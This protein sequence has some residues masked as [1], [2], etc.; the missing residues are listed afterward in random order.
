LHSIIDG[1]IIGRTLFANIVKYLRVTF[2]GNFGNLF[3]IAIA[4]AFMRFIPLLPSQLL[5]INFLSDLPA[6][7]FSFDNVDDTELRQPKKWRSD[8]IIKNG[9]TFGLI[10]TIFDLIL[11]FYLLYVLNVFEE[12]FRSV[13]FLEIILTEV[14]VIFFL[15]TTKPF[16]FSKGPSLILVTA[17]IFSTLVGFAALYPPLST[18]L[19][20]QTPVTDLILF[21]IL[22]SLGYALTTEF[23]KY[24]VYRNSDGNNF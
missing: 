6:L 3:T 2:A 19:E 17:I 14:I 23:V 5:F 15:R 12:V 21:T 22:I 11:I 24:F 1:V 16:M 20:F 13:F 9:V 4:S 18:Y 8:K 10:S 7:A